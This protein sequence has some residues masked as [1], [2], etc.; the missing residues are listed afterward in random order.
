[1]EGIP[2]LGLAAGP[3]LLQFAAARHSEN[4]LGFSGRQDGPVKGMAFRE[5]GAVPEFGGLMTI[6]MRDDF[7]GISV[8]CR[9]ARQCVAC[10]L[11]RSRPRSEDDHQ[12]SGDIGRP[13]ALRERN[14]FGRFVQADPKVHIANIAAIGPLLDGQPRLLLL[15]ERPDLID[16]NMIESQISHP[17]VEQ[18]AASIA[19]FP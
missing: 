10:K 14:H 11:L 12:P 6:P 8:A 17:F 15:N 1:V 19:I 18:I 4:T 16:L 7:P 3:D 9:S 13:L 5:A 2:L